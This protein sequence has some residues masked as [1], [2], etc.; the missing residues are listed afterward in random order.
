[1]ILGGYDMRNMKRIVA[2]LLVA[3]L[4]LSMIPALAAPQTQ[5]TIV[6]TTVDAVTGQPIQDAT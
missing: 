4:C 1:M 6:V 5:G 3:I 2:S